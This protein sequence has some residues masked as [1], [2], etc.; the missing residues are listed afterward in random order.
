MELLTFLEL[1]MY[2]FS[3]C[4][5]LQTFFTSKEEIRTIRIKGLMGKGETFTG[6]SWNFVFLDAR[7][8]LWNI[9][10]SF[11][12]DYNFQYHPI[13]FPMHNDYHKVNMLSTSMCFNIYTQFLF[14]LWAI[15][16]FIYF[17]RIRNKVIS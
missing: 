17:K 2:I 4:I 7:V 10:G 13:I 12:S 15:C 3:C 5:L 6:I 1:I 8:F 16:S 9:K 11:V 14:S